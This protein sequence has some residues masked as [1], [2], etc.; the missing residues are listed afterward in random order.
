MDF[1]SLCPGLGHFICLH[2]WNVSEACPLCCDPEFA[3]KYTDLRGQSGFSRDVLVLSMS[4]T[5]VESDQ[6]WSITVFLGPAA[7]PCLWAR[8][9]PASGTCDITFVIGGALHHVVKVAEQTAVPNQ[10][11][12]Q[13]GTLLFTAPTGIKRGGHHLS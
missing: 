1:H 5:L 10:Q 9:L 12:L 4:P 2:S 13:H 8:K 11:P 3:I 6:Q 7:S